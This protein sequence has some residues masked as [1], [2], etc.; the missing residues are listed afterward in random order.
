[1]VRALAAVTALLAL[2]AASE[3]APVERR[4]AAEEAR[5]GV[6][7]DGVHIYAIDNNRIAKYRIAD[8][9]KVASWEGPRNLFP[10]I[11][12]CAVVARELA[13]AASNYSAL[14]QTSSIE[15]FDPRTLKHLR[16]HSFGITEGSLTVLDWHA[17]A[18]WAVFAHY[19][20]RGGEPGKDNRYSQ[21]VRM[22]TRFQPQQ[23]W[24]FPPEVLALMKPH[25]ASGAS[26]S[27]DGKLALSGHDLPEI[28]I[29]RLPVAGSTL[30]LVETVA[31][32]TQ[33]Q[34]IDWDPRVKRRLWTISRPSREVFASRISLG[35]DNKEGQ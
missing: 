17:G 32:A 34:A 18:W 35:G 19:E 23:R 7:S 30:E 4:I 33:G 11:N 25:S 16:S 22:D 20:T 29:V 26:W 9:Q 21:L 28:Y 13:C 6:A 15:V 24:V 3:P 10:H 12:S 27:H 8:G 2:T 31:V 1:V 14:P 5:Q